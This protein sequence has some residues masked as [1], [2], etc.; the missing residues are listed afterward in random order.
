MGLLAVGMPVQP[1]AAAQTPIERGGGVALPSDTALLAAQQLEIEDPQPV[2]VPAPEPDPPTEQPELAP[3][4]PVVVEPD[5]VAAQAVE[6]ERPAAAAAVSAAVSAAGPGQPELLNPLGS[7]ALGRDVTLIARSTSP[8]TITASLKFLGANPVDSPRESECTSGVSTYTMNRTAGIDTAAVIVPQSEVDQIGFYLWCARLGTGTWSGA[9]FRVDSAEALGQLGGH[10]Y[11]K[12]VKGVN[13][14]NG[15]WVINR[16]DVELDSVGPDLAM[17]RT[18][19]SLDSV[20]GPLGVGWSFNYDMRIRQLTTD[21]VL[22]AVVYPDG[23]SLD[24]ERT[25]SNRWTPVGGRGGETTSWIDLE[26]TDLEGTQWVLNDRDGTAHRFDSGNGQLVEIRDIW[27]NSVGLTY[28]TDGDLYRAT[29]NRTQR[30]LQFSW[31]NGLLDA[32]SAPDPRRGFSAANRVL[33]RYE[34]HPQDP[35]F[36]WKVCDPRQVGDDQYCET[37]ER[38]TVGTASLLK[39]IYNMVP[40]TDGGAPLLAQEATYESDGR[41][42]TRIERPEAGDVHVT[43][44]AI[45]NAIGSVNLVTDANNQVWGYSKTANGSEVAAWGR[46]RV[47]GAWIGSPTAYE[48]KD[49]FRTLIQDPNGNRQRLWYEGG[50][51][52]AEANGE[53]EFTFFGYN[54]TNDVTA[55]CDNRAANTATAAVEDFIF[56]QDYCVSMTY[57]KHSLTSRTTRINSTTLADGSTV[58]NDSVER[59]VYEPATGQVITEYVPVG[60]EQPRPPRVAP[61]RLPGETPP[62]SPTVRD[63][64][65]VTYEYD[66]LKRLTY[67][68]TASGLKTRHFWNSWGQPFSAI[69]ADDET[70]Y[71]WNDYNAAGLVNK[72]IGPSNDDVVID[73]SGLSGAPES[74]VQLQTLTTWTAHREPMQISQQA[75]KLTPGEELPVGS[76]SGSIRRA[77]FHYDLLGREVRSVDPMGGEVTRTFDSRGNVETVCDANKNCTKTTFDANNRATA[78]TAIEFNDPHDTRV[79]DRRLSTMTYDPAGRLE[80]SQANGRAKIVYE[81][82]DADR[83]VSEHIENF[84]REGVPRQR[85]LNEYVYDPAGTGYIVSHKA[86][87]HVDGGGLAFTTTN[88]THTLSGLVLTSSTGVVAPSNDFYN[89]RINV[90][91][92]YAS[93]GRVKSET[94]WRGDFD[95]A[96]Q[97]QTVFYY[98]HGNVVEEHVAKYLGRSDSDGNA[99]LDYVITYSGYDKRDFLTSTTTTNRVVEN[100]VW[101]GDRYITT[102][103]TNDNNGRVVKVEHP[104]VRVIDE[105]ENERS[106]RPTVEFHYNPFGDLKHDI[107]ANGNTIVTLYDLNGRP[108]YTEYPTV[109]NTTPGERFEYDAN[110]NVTEHISRRA[111]RTLWLYDGLNRPVLESNPHPVDNVQRDTIAAFDA[112]GASTYKYDWANNVVSMTDLAG[113]VT[114]TTYNEYDLPKTQALAV[115]AESID[116]ISSPQRTYLSTFAYDDGGNLK[117]EVVN[118]RRTDYT[119]NPAGELTSV[120]DGVTANDAGSITRYTYNQLGDPLTVTDPLNR[121]AI[122]CYD[123]RGNLEVTKL[124]GPTGGASEQAGNVNC[125]RTETNNPRELQWRTE[126]RWDRAGRLKAEIDADNQRTSFAYDDLGRLIQVT[127]PAVDGR[128]AVT[129]FGYDLAGNH[130]YTK[131]ARGN[132]TRATYNAWN[133][134]ATF[135]EKDSN[136]ANPLT[137]TTT[138]DGGGLPVVDVDPGGARTSRTYNPAG[139]LVIEAT[140]DQERVAFDYDKAHRLVSAERNGVGT[141]EFNYNVAGQLITSDGPGGRTTYTYHGTTGL[142]KTRNDPSSNTAHQFTWTGREQLASHTDALT[143]IK[144]EFTYFRDGQLQTET[145]GS[146]YTRTL[147]Y[148]NAGRVKSDRAAGPNNSLTYAVDY[149]WTDRGNLDTEYIR[150]RIDNGP[151]IPNRVNDYDYDEAGRLTRWEVNHSPTFAAD[152]TFASGVNVFA[153][154][155]EYDRGG[156]R[157]SVVRTESGEPTVTENFTYDAY[158]RLRTSPE[159]TH[160]WN[161]DGTLSSIA[162][163][164]GTATFAFNDMG[165]LETH[166]TAT[167]DVV[168]YTYDAFGRLQSRGN[169][170]TFGYAGFSSEPAAHVSSTAANDLRYGRNAFG[171]ITSYQWTANSGATQ[172]HTIHLNY[173]GDYAYERNKASSQLAGVTERTPFGEIQA[174]ASIFSTEGTRSNVGFQGD[175][176]DPTTGDVNMGARW[177]NPNSGTFRKRDTY[178]GELGQPISLNRYTYGANNP[179]RYWDPTGNAAVGCPPC[180]IDPIDLVNAV[181]DVAEAIVD[182]FPGGDNGT[183]VTTVGGNP[184]PTPPGCSTGGNVGGSGGGSGGQ[185]RL[186]PHLWL[187]PGNRRWEQWRLWPPLW[188]HPRDRRWG[189]WRNRRHGRHRRRWDDRDQC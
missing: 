174:S 102:N 10:P 110:G 89:S 5:V 185:W 48:Y 49:G 181:V 160:N 13:V 114:T 54:S 98:D 24:F 59:W 74:G 161:S 26:G 12:F 142:L 106:A 180:I 107:D 79:L 173:R 71:E 113:A 118:G 85:R 61:P 136:N 77:T 131:N 88:Y 117:S 30:Y 175:Y 73:W 28:D 158:N 182:A 9:I 51:L 66:G 8:L 40:R 37:Y 31:N 87:G 170:V 86:G 119:W 91:Y 78:V 132:I 177:Y 94:R 111:F 172:A 75:F 72:Q 53:D 187:H 67:S 52:I 115:P 169:D 139:L 176:T 55:I 171:S 69:D 62:A 21:Q 125:G 76:T 104:T 14:V 4:V 7:V 168:D 27:G 129:K 42:E 84:D 153:E 16:D 144:N 99:L 167:G 141:Q 11:S 39:G 25:S 96:T 179:A 47:D 18:Y 20:P 101:K 100:E 178:A 127:A 93:S 45:S 162:G 44:F 38:V 50:N 152:G 137:W 70:L 155:Y 105:N 189:R 128:R 164:D 103:Y 134:E 82:D 15:N 133:L 156:N 3:M 163:P 123:G 58:T 183:T 34:Y 122:Y 46:W 95:G 116:G 145:R 135:S 2:I 151:R 36:L 126:Q 43:R 17:R 97:S 32:V 140:S 112:I 159:G 35:N 29:N 184:C 157:T 121:K 165:E 60:G 186:W 108:T 19:N 154:D 90:R 68:T 147:S 80:S 6:G 64:D 148:D 92:S 63:F 120:A 65:V 81:Y 150:T 41:I 22:L 56:N 188:L 1:V 130:V 33:W 23:S 124:Y 138:Y 83:L 57:Q 166:R 109:G 146:N 143:G 149:T